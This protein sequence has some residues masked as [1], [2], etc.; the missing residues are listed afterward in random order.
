LKEQALV[1]VRKFNA[2]LTD[3]QVL[4]HVARNTISKVT[5][6]PLKDTLLGLEAELQ[7]A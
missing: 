6:K 4:K 1:R 3:N 5:L 7:G 2:K